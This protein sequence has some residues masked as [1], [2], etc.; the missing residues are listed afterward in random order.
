METFRK[1]L[2][3][4]LGMLLEKHQE[5]LPWRMSQT[6]NLLQLPRE[7][8]T[9]AQDC[10]AKETS[11]QQRD[12]NVEEEPRRVACIAEGVLLGPLTAIGFGSTA[13]LQHFQLD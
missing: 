11:P 5:T 7:K 4:T 3:A 8:L 9:L 12:P 2:R 13:E 6:G 1:W 10:R